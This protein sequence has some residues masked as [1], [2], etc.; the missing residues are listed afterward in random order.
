M[1]LRFQVFSFHSTFFF[2]S[3]LFYS[4]FPCFFSL[5]A[6]TSFLNAVS[7]P[8]I[9]MYRDLL[10]QWYLVSLPTGVI[11]SLR[12]SVSVALNLISMVSTSQEVPKHPGEMLAVGEVKRPF[13]TSSGLK[14]GPPALMQFSSAA[15]MTRHG[16]FV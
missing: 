13:K 7:P 10:S 12:Q 3:S 4:L 15:C 6:L 11:V 16:A 8:C 2:A 9:G 5:L 1:S 14:P